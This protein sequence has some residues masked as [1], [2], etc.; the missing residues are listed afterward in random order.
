[1]HSGNKIKGYMHFHVNNSK[2]FI[3]KNKV[4]IILI[5]EQHSEHSNYEQY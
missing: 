4:Q 5:S 2:L 1:M 3:K